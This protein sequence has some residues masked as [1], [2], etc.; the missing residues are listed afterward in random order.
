MGDILH[1]NI[2]SITGQGDLL[3]PEFENK[4]GTERIF[5]DKLETWD[6]LFKGWSVWK[7]R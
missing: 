3:A 5:I 1:P 2:K 7:W 6:K 4:I